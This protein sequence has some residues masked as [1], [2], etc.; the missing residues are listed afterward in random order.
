M[1]P[2][3]VVGII[4]VF[5]SGGALGAAGTLLG[6]WV[7]R[8]VQGEEESRRVAAPEYDLLRGEV[9]ELS[10][11]L[12]MIDARLDF[13]EQLLG[14]QLPVARP[15]PPSLDDGLSSDSAHGDPSPGLS[16]SRRPTPPGEDPEDAPG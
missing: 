14:G 1:D 5:V 12:H 10:R 7:L 8:K 6:Q 16:T 2:E 15:E 4:A 3:I 13:T 11:K 9:S